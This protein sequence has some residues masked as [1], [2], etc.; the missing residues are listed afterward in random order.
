MDKVICGL[1]ISAGYAEECLLHPLLST[2]VGACFIRFVF[3]TLG[4]HRFFNF[5]LKE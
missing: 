1:S 5:E 4:A 3:Q 2:G